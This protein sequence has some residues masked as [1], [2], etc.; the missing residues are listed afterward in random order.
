MSDQ[1][2][3]PSTPSTL[4]I[5][6]PPQKRSRRRRVI[7]R[8]IASLTLGLLSTLTLSWVVPPLL[9]GYGLI[10]HT[11]WSPD[12]F[13]ASRT[14]GGHY[15]VSH[16]AL[17]DWVRFRRIIFVGAIESQPYFMRNPPPEWACVLS[18]NPNDV[19]EFERRRH[20]NG[21][22]IPSPPSDPA[23]TPAPGVLNLGDLTATMARQELLKAGPIPFE[24]VDT[25][26][27]GWPF[28]A[29]ASE[30][31]F[32]WNPAPGV[33]G[34]VRRFNIVL[35]HVARGRVMLPL[36]PLWRGILL[37]TALFA[38]G[39]ASLLFGVTAA[40]SL[41]RHLRGR[42]TGCGYDLR[43]KPDQ[44]CPECGRGLA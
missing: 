5:P 43:G 44:G 8:A 9:L 6:K 36:R 4:L 37:D 3:T 33:P 13:W 40:R 21:Q 10:A 32:R 15:T 38:A 42:C 24:S 20:A 39:W 26:A 14:H 16:L 41:T 19:P 11:T 12:T 25:A 23:T 27:T 34:E 1:V 17:S 22:S 2:V 28:R 7:T 18:L 35:K 31:W 30:A 29:F